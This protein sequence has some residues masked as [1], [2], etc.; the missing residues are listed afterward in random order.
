MT[1]T[2]C[3]LGPAMKSSCTAPFLEMNKS[4]P[5]TRTQVDSGLEEMRRASAAMKRVS[6]EEMK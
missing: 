5:V 2:D 1:L 4:F 3:P 6:S